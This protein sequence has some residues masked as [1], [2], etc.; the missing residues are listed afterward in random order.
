MELRDPGHTLVVYGIR[1]IGKSVLAKMVGEDTKAH[2]RS[3]RSYHLPPSFDLSAFYYWLA[4]SAVP[5][6]LAGAGP[7]ELAQAVAL[8][9]FNQ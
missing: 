1:G 6:E 2:F 7:E 5:K 8:Q 9:P 4:G 3:V